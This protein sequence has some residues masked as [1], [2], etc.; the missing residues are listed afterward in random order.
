MKHS[1]RTWG[2]AV[3]ALSL[4]SFALAAQ[5]FLIKRTP[6]EGDVARYKITADIALAGVEVNFSA[7][8]ESKVTK[9]EENG[10]YTSESRQFNTKVVIAGQEQ[11]IPEQGASR[12]TYNSRG[13]MV[14]YQGPDESGGAWRL[15]VLNGFYMPEKAVNVGDTWTYEIKA[16]SKKGTVDAKA[17]FK[18][19]GEEKVDT[20]DTVKI[21]SNV[22]ET[23]NDAASIKA[24]Y[25]L[26]KTN[27]EPVKAEGEWLNV[28]L[29][30][31]PA[32]VNA[33]FKLVREK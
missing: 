4:A 25:W 31:A 7:T 21:E 23:G 19:L 24:T 30:G 15:A 22:S 9:V 29:P 13:E 3:A 26:S 28:P 11:D 8:E 10:N 33:K 2:A 32:P 16:D 12:S 5:G 17:T 1:I 20:E 18:V 14:G 6:K 27:W